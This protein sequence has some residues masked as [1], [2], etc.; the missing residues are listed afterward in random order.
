MTFSESS[1]HIVEVT[2]VDTE[3][4]LEMLFELIYCHT[5]GCFLHFFEDFL[6]IIMILW[7]LAMG[8]MIMRIIEE[9]KLELFR[10]IILLH[11]LQF[12]FMSARYAFSIHIRSRSS[13]EAISM[14]LYWQSMFPIFL[15]DEIPEMILIIN[16]L[17]HFFILREE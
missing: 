8:C 15:S 13:L 9:D 11:I 10:T 7:R 14:R 3:L 16:K 5:F 1:Q 2:V 17:E 6:K 4:I 12:L